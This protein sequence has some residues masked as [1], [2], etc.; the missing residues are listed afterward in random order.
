MFFLNFLDSSVSW[1]V[2]FQGATH[3]NPMERTTT[4][5]MFYKKIQETFYRS[6]SPAESTEISHVSC[7]M[8]A[9]LLTFSYVW[10]FA[11][12][13]YYERL[14]NVR[15]SFLVKLLGCLVYIMT[16]SF[17][18]FNFW[19]WYYF[20]VEVTNF[21]PFCFRNIHIITVHDIFIFVIFHVF[22]FYLVRLLAFLKNRR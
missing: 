2:Y 13:T 1:Q 4:S 20:D 3:G 16:F 19:S 11:M 12:A 10:F 22:Q 15:F 21:I 9:F 7:L 14:T 6:P 5:G 17:F 18:A 8:K